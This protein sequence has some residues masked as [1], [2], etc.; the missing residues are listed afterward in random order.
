LRQS[1]ELGS[2]ETKDP[3]LSQQGKAE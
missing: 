1:E 2:A 3:A